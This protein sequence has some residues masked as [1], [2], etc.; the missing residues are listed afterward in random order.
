MDMRPYPTPRPRSLRERAV[1]TLARALRIPG[2]GE[3]FGQAQLENQPLRQLQNF[4]F[5]QPTYSVSDDTRVNYEKA[6]ALYANT[7]PAYKLGAGFSRPIV[8]ST[9]GFMNVPTPS[10]TD[11]NAQASD[12]VMSFFA[13]EE[14]RLYLG[15][16][17]CLR[18]GDAFLRIDYARDKFT[19]QRRFHIR[20]LIPDNVNPTPDV[21]TGGW[22]SLEIRYPVTPPQPERPYTVIERITATTRTVEVDGEVK[23]EIREY[24]TVSEPNPWG[25]IPVV[26]F[27][28]ESG[29]ES[30]FGHSDLEPLEP[31]FRAYHD[32]LLVGIGGIQL[33]AK[34]H[35]QFIL[36]DVDRFINDN[37]PE[38]ARTGQVNFQGRELM[39][40]QEG[41]S[42]S[43]LT[44]APGTDGV[45][46]LLNILFYLIVQTSET[47]EFIMGNAI[48][49]SKASADT[50]LTPYTKHI[51]RKR[52]QFSDPYQELGSLF[53]S[54]ARQVGKVPELDSYDITLDWPEITPRDQGS[55]TSAIK[56]LM[57]AFVAGVQAGLIS[58]ESAS[59]FLRPFVDTMLPWS[60]PEEDDDEQRRIIA[61]Y[62]FLDYAQSGGAP[63]P[64]N[65]T[66]AAT[67]TGAT[68]TTPAIPGTQTQPPAPID[69]Q[70]LLQRLNAG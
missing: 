26:H 65:A 51:E 10:H 57:D 7:L 58:A 66:Q 38:A 48:A 44:A 14:A 39:F 60:A 8:N 29:P 53:L 67:A 11:D 22:Q 54:M 40:M 63:G 21:L 49:S 2:V 59:E 64:E 35:V 5:W 52:L 28:N 25:V 9:A 15:A 56:T 42:A 24:Y 30:S 18:D 1:A 16:R 12:L 43:F 55:I 4:G 70:A 62:E 68:A 41:E 36:K 13:N 46:N 3:Q 31:L 32:T 27:K 19:T 20:T 34:P 33:F 47:P 50:Q 17:D 61:G 37:F 23:P 6:R 69:Y 45:I